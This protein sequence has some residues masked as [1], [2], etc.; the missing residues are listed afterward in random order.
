MPIDTAALR[1]ELQ[2]DLDAADAILTR[3]QGEARELTLDE[4]S[5]YD[6]L[7]DATKLT[8]GKL[9]RAA[10]VDKVREAYLNGRVENGFGGPNV[11]IRRDPWQ[12]ETRTATSTDLRTRALSAL[13]SAPGDMP[14][15]ARQY[16]TKLIEAD[17]DNE[18][19]M[20]RYVI[21]ASSPAYLRAFSAWFRNPE[22]G[23]LEWDDAQREAY[24][25][26]QR[27]SRTMSIGTTTAGGFLVPV[28]LDPQ[29]LISGTGSVNPM[30]DV[31]RV[32]TTAAN[33]TEFVTSAGV[34]ASWDAE[35][36]AVS[37]DS[38]TLAQPSITA[39]K[40]QA[41]IPV[42]FELF[43]DSNIGSQVGALLADSKAQLESAAFTTGSGSGA[44]KGVITSLVAGS[45]SVMTS[46][47]SAIA[48]ADMT[49]VQNA[50]PP[51]WRPNA[52]WMLNLAIMNQARTLPM[53]TNGPALLAGDSTTI[54]GWTVR[55]NSAVDGTI[56]AGTTHDYVVLAGDFKQYI[57][58]DRIGSTIEFVPNLFDTSTG[59]PT[60]T[61]GFL[62]HWR[63]GGDVVI[64]DAF[65]LLDYNG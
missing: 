19:R 64:Q 56:A 16:A 53:Y 60:G 62:M 2:R 39:Y 36:A 3:A 52:I 6:L 20:A 57:I 27:M 54:L 11:I 45:A 35:N 44:P 12:D 38:P 47:G 18:S 42:S 9:E 31:C 34:T 25:R 21:E 24:G 23:H 10:K 30:R 13:E 49:S 26:V 28:Q 55:E 32:E 50:L 59:R 65:R 8:T 43:E 51:R 22:R 37:D 33:V 14:D 48:I 4:T 15:G 61:R 29:I 1:G 17:T 40:G 46:A 5:E 63:T 58:V 7:L 41:F